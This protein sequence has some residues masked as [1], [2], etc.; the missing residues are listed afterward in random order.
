ME[1]AF[2][3]FESKGM[4]GMYCAKCGNQLPDDALFCTK[5]GTKINIGDQ[6]NN[7]NTSNMNGMPRR[8]LDQKAKL[9]RILI[10]VGI[11]AVA[12]LVLIVG[13][14]VAG[15]LLGARASDRGTEANGAADNK[16]VSIF[17][18]SGIGEEPYNHET[19]N[20][21]TVGTPIS[22]MN[23]GYANYPYPSELGSI[24]YYNGFTYYVEELVD[25]NDTLEENPSLKGS[26]IMRVSDDNTEPELVAVNEGEEV[27][28]YLTFFGDQLYALGTDDVYNMYS[29]LEMS[30]SEEST[31]ETTKD[32][33]VYKIDTKGGKINYLTTIDHVGGSGIVSEDEEGYYFQTSQPEGNDRQRNELVIFHASDAD[34]ERVDLGSWRDWRGSDVSES[35]E[36]YFP[37]GVYMGRAYYARQDGG[38]KNSII[39]YNLSG[40]DEKTVFHIEGI[41]NFLYNFCNF[42]WHFSQMYPGM[43]DKSIG[44]NCIFA[45]DGLYIYTGGTTMGSGYI[46]NPSIERID[47]NTGE[48]TKA[49]ELDTSDITS[50]TGLTGTN[51]MDVWRKTISIAVDGTLS[52]NDQEIYTILNKLSD[53]SDTESGEIKLPNYYAEMIGYGGNWIY[54]VG[55]DRTYTVFAE[56]PLADYIT[57]EKRQEDVGIGFYRINK[58]TGE[59]D[60]IPMYEELTD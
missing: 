22:L 48:I 4:Q 17:D 19:S 53:D 43:Y 16:F 9:S 30:T 27:L 10:G 14:V 35:D 7:R 40:E 55:F 5:C 24:A 18:K 36:A 56:T 44:A 49:W 37:L 20:F 41:G 45:N 3:R 42:Q 8:K 25:V 31:Y 29:S 33:S 39:S 58:D 59:A 51:G 11:G 47:L 46:E 12:A 60:F 38:Q 2:C 32:Y 6:H 50:D 1:G 54:T 15:D 23:S 34:V 28:G 26:K 13:I 57:E 21:R 52:D